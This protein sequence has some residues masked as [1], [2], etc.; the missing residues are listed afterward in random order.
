M[1]EIIYLGLIRDIYTIVSMPSN[2]VVEYGSI[3]E[4]KNYLHTHTCLHMI[5]MLLH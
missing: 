5:A 1:S 4:A 3:S 2:I